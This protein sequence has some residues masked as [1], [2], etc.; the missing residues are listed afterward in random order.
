MQK[1]FLL[2]ALLILLGS[3]TAN[4]LD[5]GKFEYEFLREN[6]N[7]ARICGPAKGVELSGALVIPSTVV[8]P[9]TGE[10]YTIVEIGPAGGNV[11]D[12]DRELGP[13]C[14]LPK[15]T[16]VTIPE[17][18]KEIWDECFT[19]CTGITKYIVRLA[20]PS[21]KSVDGLL[22]SKDENDK[23][24]DLIR[25]PPASELTS[26]TIGDRA[27][28]ASP[29]FIHYGAFRDNSTLRTLQLGKYTRMY[30][31]AF[32]GNLGI[33]EIKQGNSDW[34]IIDGCMFLDDGTTLV[35]V[36][37]A[38]VGKD[39]FTVPAC[40]KTIYD[41]ACASLQASWID[42]SNVERIERCAFKGSALKNVKIPATVKSFDYGLFMDCR[43]LETVTIETKIT[44]LDYATFR[45]CEKLT[46][47][48]LP[49]SCKKLY[50]EVFKGCKSLESF[51]LANYTEMEVEGYVHEEHFAQSGLKKMNWPSK[52]TSVPPMCFFK[53]ADLAT[54][55]FGNT[56]ECI[57]N[58]A[59][60]GTALETFNTGNLKEVQDYAFEHTLKMRKIV[61][62][63]SDHTL[64]LGVNCSRVNTDTQVFI[65]HKDIKYSG[66]YGDDWGYSFYGMSEATFYTSLIDTTCFPDTWETLYC[67]WGVTSKFLVFNPWGVAEE[68]F[69][70]ER[71]EDNSFTVTPN[72]SWVKI[73]EVK[74]TSKELDIRYTAK[75]VKMH[76][77][78]PMKFF[79]DIETGVES[80]ADD[81]SVSVTTEGN[82]LKIDAPA[83]TLCRVFDLN[84]RP[85]G[86]C[87]ATPSAAIQLPSKGLYILMTGEGTSASTRK[88]L[89]R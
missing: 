42:F 58:L 76:T 69:T 72:Y 86:D 30:V 52:V 5:I 8:R 1:S 31:G 60:Y 74:Q 21:F 53:C 77:V 59:F 18:V 40:V 37:P 24:G 23:A 56:T 64:K 19:G 34:V 45:N 2:A 41:Y 79:N 62:P 87:R 71:G 46:T 26:F 10:E 13:F 54:F 39:K 88:I 27:S 80:L 50:A 65:D 49:S 28:F 17:T 12:D 7:E 61:I 47:V 57:Q 9:S 33:K 36:P 16:S 15:I 29:R 35:A 6:P 44:M 83:G 70:V 14:D 78:Y 84:G 48:N 22:Y 67:P 63:E 3:L 81:S 66:W 38:R 20:N 73:T 75:D 43:K 85:V 82:L 55:T 51:S 25:F 89:C 32:A 68:M 11:R 4:A